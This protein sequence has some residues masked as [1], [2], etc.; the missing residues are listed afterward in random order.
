MIIQTQ[1]KERVPEF[2]NDPACT[3]EID[4]QRAVIGKKPLELNNNEEKIW[5]NN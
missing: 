2:E 1:L 5:K 4:R 3:P